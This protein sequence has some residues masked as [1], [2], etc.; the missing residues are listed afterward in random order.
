V[1]QLSLKGKLFDALESAELNA[2]AVPK[3]ECES[4]V[5]VCAEWN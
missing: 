1:K 2:V 4:C 5:S 3:L